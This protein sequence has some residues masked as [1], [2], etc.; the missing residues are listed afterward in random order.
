MNEPTQA[1][2]ELERLLHRTLRAVP[3]RRAPQ[4]LESRVLGELQRRAAMPWWRR[5][6]VHWPQVAR[7][8][9]VLLCVA[10]AAAVVGAT[11]AVVGATGEWA[12]SLARAVPPEWI[13]DGLA[14]SGL[15]YTAL[16]GL[17][18]AA[19]RTLYRNFEIAGDLRS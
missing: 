10:M 17:G 13:Y 5:S 11:A 2:Q 1:E 16:F 18:I 4:T 12:A 15:L 19:Y 9:F 7:A 6:F 8:A 3:L 14:V